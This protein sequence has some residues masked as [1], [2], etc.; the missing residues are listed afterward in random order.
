MERLQ[1]PARDT[2]YHTWAGVDH[3][4][5]SDVGRCMK[6]N[7][8]RLVWARLLHVQDATTIYKWMLQSGQKR[9]VKEPAL[10][11]HGATCIHTD[12]GGRVCG[13]AVAKDAPNGW[14]CGFHNRTEKAAL[15]EEVVKP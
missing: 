8:V 3:Q 6:Q 10:D 12:L 9:A 11:V 4:N 5:I 14:L 7:S 13:K 15:V 2:Y 1:V